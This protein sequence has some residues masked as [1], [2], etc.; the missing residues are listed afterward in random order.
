[1]KGMTNEH[2]EDMHLKDHVR[3]FWKSVTHYNEQG[4][5]PVQMLP[6]HPEDFPNVTRIN[7][8]Y[9]GEP[10]DYCGQLFPYPVE[11]HH[12]CEEFINEMWKNRPS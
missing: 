4:V 12:Q 11:R 6:V 10:C 3:A 5:V 1:M 8:D 7:P 2:Q 9:F